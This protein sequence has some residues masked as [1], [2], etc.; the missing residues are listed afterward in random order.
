MTGLTCDAA[1]PFA[2]ISLSMAW[3]SMALS[4]AVSLPP[5]RETR[6]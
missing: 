1:M 3:R 4:M 6:A 2:R 5:S